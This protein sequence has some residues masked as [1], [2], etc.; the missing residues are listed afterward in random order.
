MIST[1]MSPWI[2]S[3]LR[4][5]VHTPHRQVVVV[6]VGQ[7]HPTHH[8]RYHTTHLEK[9]RHHVTQNPEYVCKGHLS[10]LAVRQKSAL[11]EYPAAQKSS[12]QSNQNWS[13]NC[14]HE[15][16]H[17][18]LDDLPSRHIILNLIEKPS[19][20][21]VQNNSYSI[22]DQPFP[23]N[24]RKQLGVLTCL[25]EGQGCHTIRSWYCCT[26]LYNKCSFQFIKLLLVT[27]GNN[28]TELTNEESKSEGNCE[29]DHGSQ[30]SI[31]YDIKHIFPEI[32]L[33]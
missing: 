33:L 15:T 23:K 32:L 8:H 14:P 25:D 22:V 26:V 31:G 6:V 5:C 13:H 1:G 16:A 17:N 27:K 10:H 12:H 18:R 30:N 3:S 7:R 19:D 2:I 24:N 28:P 29:G 20:N 11:L 4:C 9:L 21:L